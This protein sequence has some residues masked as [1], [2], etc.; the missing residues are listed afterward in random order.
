MPRPPRSSQ[1]ASAFSMP[2]ARCGRSRP[3]QHPSRT[4]RTAVMKT[5]ISTDVNN[6]IAGVL[7]VAAERVSDDARLNELVT[8]SFVLVEL[9]VE[10]Q[11][12]FDVHFFQEDLRRVVTVGDL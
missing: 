6:A 12:M 7:R 9:V 10:L 3:T 11:E 4:Q 5:F 2:P 8:D 1:I